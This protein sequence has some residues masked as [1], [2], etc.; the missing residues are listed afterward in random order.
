LCRGDLFVNKLKNAGFQDAAFGEFGKYDCSALMVRI[1]AIFS[2]DASEFRTPLCN[3]VKVAICC[4]NCQKSEAST[5]DG[6]CVRLYGATKALGVDLV[7]N[8]RFFVNFN[9]Q[10]YVLPSLPKQ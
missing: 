6:V 1:P 3:D 9:C 4:A 2:H 8:W 10:N 5:Q 7:C